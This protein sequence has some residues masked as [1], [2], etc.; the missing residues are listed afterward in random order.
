M[1]DEV[2]WGLREHEIGV[3]LEQMLMQI[4]D[5]H[6]QIHEQEH[7]FILKHRFQ[8]AILHHVNHPMGQHVRD[9]KMHHHQI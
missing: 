2:I 7:H 4:H 8:F 3:H 6:E 9:L 5:I 1:I